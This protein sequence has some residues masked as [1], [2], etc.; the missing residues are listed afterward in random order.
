MDDASGY[1]LAPFSALLNTIKYS[2]SD[3]TEVYNTLLAVLSDYDP[4]DAK[5][6][7]KV[8]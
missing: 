1:E 6:R 5:N 8:R 3:K 7:E 2:C 4:D